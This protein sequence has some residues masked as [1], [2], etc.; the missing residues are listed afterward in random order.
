MITEEL[1]M[2]KDS[3]VMAAYYLNRYDNIRLVSF[4]GYCSGEY[5]EGNNEIYLGAMYVYNLFNGGFVVFPNDFVKIGD[6]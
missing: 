2:H 5:F 1:W 3:N 6:V 4:A